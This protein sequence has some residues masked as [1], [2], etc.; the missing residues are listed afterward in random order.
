MKNKKNMKDKKRNMKNKKNMKDK[1][2]NMKNKKNMKNKWNKSFLEQSDL[3][4]RPG[5]RSA[6]SMRSGREEA[7]RTQTPSRPST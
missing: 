6:G 3:S 5:L 2:R 7:A 4:S 1:K